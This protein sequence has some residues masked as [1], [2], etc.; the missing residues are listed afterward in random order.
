MKLRIYL[1]LANAASILV[2]V[3]LLILF[4]HYM[5]LSQKQFIWLT[6]ASL[7]SGIVSGALHFM[8]M[9]PVEAAVKQIG[10]GSARIAEGRLDARVPLVGP[11][12]LKALAGQF[13]EMGDKLQASF[14]QLQAAE[15]ARQELVANMA[16][17]LRTP[18]ASLQAYAEALEDGVVSDEAAVRRY[19]GTIRSETIHLGR[20]MQQLFELSTLDSPIQESGEERLAAEPC[21]I[22]DA[23]LELLPRFAP[24]LEAASLGIEVRLPERSLYGRLPAQSLQRILQN[25]LEN[26]IRYSPQKGAIRIEGR[27]EPGNMVRLTI[28]DEGPGVPPEEREKIFERFYRTDRSRGRR[29]GGAGLGLSIAKSLVEQAGGSIGL[30]CPPEGGSSFWFTVQGTALSP[31]QEGAAK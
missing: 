20:L 1:L 2:I 16:H 12:E 31:L 19:M 8:L 25:L 13:N 30:H 10:E 7:G 15:I 22:E 3:A 24:Q 27:Q 23:L 14:R 17:D 11:A 4:Y 29:S 28:A 26:A 6:V 5:L 18:L 21:L 9:R